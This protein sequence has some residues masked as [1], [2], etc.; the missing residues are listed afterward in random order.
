MWDT[1]DLALGA[2]SEF[3][4]AVFEENRLM[5]P[6]S[7]RRLKSILDRVPTA[8]IMGEKD[9]LAPPASVLGIAQ[10]GLPPK[11]FRAEGKGHVALAVSGSVLKTLWP[12]YADW[13]IS[14]ETA[15]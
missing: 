11:V 4:R 9:D 7:L 3:N 1:P 6:D 14:P 13:L 10:T 5:R 2:W 12:E 8:V 15:P